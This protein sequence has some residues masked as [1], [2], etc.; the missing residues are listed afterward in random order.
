[1]SPTKCAQRGL[2]LCTT[3][4]LAAMAVTAGTPSPTPSPAPSVPAQPAGA[5]PGDRGSRT[6]NDAA[7]VARV[8][9]EYGSGVVIDWIRAKR[10]GKITL[11]VNG[12]L[13]PS[14]GPPNPRF[15]TPASVLH[16]LELSRVDVATFQAEIAGAVPVDKDQ[17][18]IS[19]ADV[20]SGGSSGPQ[21]RGGADSPTSSQVAGNQMDLDSRCRASAR[22]LVTTAATRESCTSVN[23][24]EIRSD[25]L[26]KMNTATIYRVTGSCV[27]TSDGRVH[28]F[29]AG[30]R[31]HVKPIGGRIW[32]EGSATP[33]TTSVSTGLVWLKVAE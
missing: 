1:M 19:Q 23:I 13:R 25:A 31:C 8:L 22:S 24:T 32:A 15:V 20:A 17:M 2:V 14:I 11:E 3:T 30:A 5:P 6:E 4:M 29:D 33:T 26:P 12:R 9:D 18:V 21:S 10:R 28:P 16:D 27:A 7:A